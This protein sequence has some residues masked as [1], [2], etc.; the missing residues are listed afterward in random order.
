M[1]HLLY[2]GSKRSILELCNHLTLYLNLFFS[3]PCSHLEAVSE[4]EDVD[5]RR[6]AVHAVPVVELAKVKV[7]ARL[8][9]WAVGRD[10]VRR[11]EGGE[12]AVPVVELAKA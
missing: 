9:G 3:Y 2:W 1:Q 4:L 12:S 10:E 11:D 8:D 6:G 5:E 7:P